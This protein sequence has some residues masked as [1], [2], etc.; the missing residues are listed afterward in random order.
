MRMSS[1]F[2]PNS[3]SKKPMK[4]ISLTAI[5]SRFEGLGATLESLLEQ[6]AD[7]VRLN[8]PTAYRRFPD[9]DGTLPSVP[10]GVSII[11]CETD[12]GPATKILPAAKAFRGQDVQIL[13]C[14]D[15]CIVPRGWADRL[16]KIQA[17]RPN[18]AVAVYVRASYL[19]DT[20]L[21]QGRQAW[22]VPITYDLPYR[23]SRLAQKLFGTQTA[24][25]RPFL[26]PGYGDVFFGA[27]GVVVRP[28]FFDDQAWDIPQI[29]WLVDDVWLSA[30]LARKGIRI[31]C[32]WR[33][34]LPKAQD[35]S[36]QDALLALTFQ[37]KDRQELNRAAAQY[38]RDSFGIWR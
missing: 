33:A 31:Y 3:V 27:G 28:E 1:H 13:F 34:A 24:Y 35:T 29:A 4:I 6:E 7:Q 14:D 26:I 12:F 8:I 30:M 38:C 23:M 19:A 15:D 32:P 5:P 16:F 22:Q 9:W 25:H 21:P 2:I 18:Q 17:R 37:G 20:S 10:A 11:R 36:E